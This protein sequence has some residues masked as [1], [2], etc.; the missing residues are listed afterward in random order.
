MEKPTFC[1]LSSITSATICELLLVE[2]IRSKEISQWDTLEALG[3]IQSQSQKVEAA[4][5]IT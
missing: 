5:F 4:N 2:S 3:H 1:N